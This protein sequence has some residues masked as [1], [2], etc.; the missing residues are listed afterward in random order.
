MIT[1]LYIQNKKKKWW[2]RLLNAK[3]SQFKLKSTQ[4]PITQELRDQE[5]HI[6]QLRGAVRAK[7]QPLKVAQVHML[8]FSLL[9]LFLTRLHQGTTHNFISIGKTCNAPTSSWRWSLPWFSPRDADRRSIPTSYV[10]DV[11]NLGESLNYTTWLIFAMLMYWWGCQ[12]WNLEFL[13][14]CRYAHCRT[15]TEGPT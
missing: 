11:M 8:L 6:E 5:K 12:K 1:F 15:P 4:S 2:R 7:G 14:N 13:S 3:R 10:Y 9:L